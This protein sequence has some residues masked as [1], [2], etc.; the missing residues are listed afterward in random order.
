MGR[1]WVGGKEAGG[2]GGEPGEKIVPGFQA[3]IDDGDWAHG[4]SGKEIERLGNCLNVSPEGEGD[5]AHFSGLSALHV[6]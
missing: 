3:G 4:A 5:H 6:V 2:R 1:G